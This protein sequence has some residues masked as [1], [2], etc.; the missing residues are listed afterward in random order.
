MAAKLIFKGI[1]F[2]EILSFITGL[3]LQGF[4][5]DWKPSCLHEAKACLRANMEKQCRE[6]EQEKLMTFEPWNKFW[7]KLDPLLDFIV[8]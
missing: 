4:M 3:D 8:R 7:L 2:K 1:E 5:L 6:M